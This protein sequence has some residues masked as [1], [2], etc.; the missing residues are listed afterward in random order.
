MKNKTHLHLRRPEGEDI[1]SKF[2]FWS[3]LFFPRSEQP[4]INITMTFLPHRGIKH[5]PD[6]THQAGRSRSSSAHVLNVC[7]C[8]LNWSQLHRVMAPTRRRLKLLQAICPSLLPYA[9]SSFPGVCPT[10]CRRGM[11]TQRLWR[12]CWVLWSRWYLCRLLTV[13]LTHTR[14]VS[15][16]RTGDADWHGFT[17]HLAWR[18]V[19][20]NSK[21]LRHSPHSLSF[22]V[23]C[24]RHWLCS[25]WMLAYC[26]VHT[27]LY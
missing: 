6:R 8:R 19:R 17:T 27:S 25:E 4:G 22:Q 13:G 16:C 9:S 11:R 23:K 21:H 15:L 5:S 26:L 7:M 18:W 12:T 20:E 2:S 3:C 14:T 24:G 1:F 10:W